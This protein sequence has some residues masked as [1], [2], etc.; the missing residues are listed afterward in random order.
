[1]LDRCVG[2]YGGIEVAR[3]GSQLTVKLGGRKL[4]LFAESP[5]KFFAKTTDLQIEFKPD[6][7]GK[8]N[9]MVRSVGEGANVAQRDKQAP[10]KPRL[11]ANLFLEQFV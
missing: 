7:D 10:S 3:E 8:V 2:T 1:M 9:E 4:L 5:T 11:T 6:A